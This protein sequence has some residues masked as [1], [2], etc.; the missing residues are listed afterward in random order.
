MPPNIPI[1]TDICPGQNPEHE[2]IP[3]TLELTMNRVFV[4]TATGAIT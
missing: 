1:N 2:G 3:V 4:C